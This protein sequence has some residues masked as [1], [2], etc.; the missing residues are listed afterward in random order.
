VHPLH[1]FKIVLL[2]GTHRAFLLEGKTGRRKSEISL[3]LVLGLQLSFITVDNKFCS[4]SYLFFQ[5]SIANES[6]I[7]QKR[8]PVVGYLLVVIKPLF[9]KIVSTWS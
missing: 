2:Q 6:K 3:V 7:A 5:A 8:I 9:L 1:K 4:L